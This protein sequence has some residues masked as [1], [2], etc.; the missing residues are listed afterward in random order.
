ME[1]RGYGRVPLE[2]RLPRN[3]LAHV[4]KL[5][6]LESSEATTVELD[7]EVVW[8][9]SVP[10]SFSTSPSPLSRIV[11]DAETVAFALHFSSNMVIIAAVTLCRLA[12]RNVDQETDEL[13]IKAFNFEFQIEAI[14]GGVLENT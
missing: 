14:Q 10:A 6:E 8:N 12:R 4:R 7:E 1:G 11:S 13:Q 5:D 3:P 2:I 9:P